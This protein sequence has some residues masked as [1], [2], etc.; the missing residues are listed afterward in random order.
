V[1]PR[2]LA[3]GLVAALGC[4][5]DAAIDA[6]AASTGAEAGPAPIRVSGEVRS[7][8]SFDPLADAS[9]CILG[10]ADAC[11]STAAD[12]S[13]ALEVVPAGD[14]AIDVTVPDQ[15][16]TVVAV[17]SREGDAYLNVFVLPTMVVEAI[18]GQLGATLDPG[19]SVLAV[20]RSTEGATATLSSGEGPF[21]FVGMMPDPMATSTVGQG[22]VL[23]LEV[24][25]GEATFT[26]VHPTET[27][28]P[29]FWD[30]GGDAERVPFAAGAL[31]YA[32][33]IPCY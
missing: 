5:D 7:A 20:N 4:G 28:D 10:A 29:P 25:P 6:A 26:F 16:R 33:R 11:T 18:A 8:L 30:G 3:A 12:G 31:T 17:S 19:R 21:Y 13:F 1:K 14:V 9:V 15:M 32:E 27:C 23:F 22:G 24:E 2:L